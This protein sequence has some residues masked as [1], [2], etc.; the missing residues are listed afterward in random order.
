VKRAVDWFYR[1]LQWL[2]TTLMALLIIPVVMQ[3]LSRH[4]DFVPRYI[5]TEEIARF[6]FIWIIMLGS[7]IAVR[8]GSHFDLDVLP[9]P[10]TERGRAIASLIKHG[11]MFLVAA[12]FL[13]FGYEFSLF[14]LSQESDLL[15]LNMLWIYGAWPLAG[16][17]YVI[18]LIEKIHADVRRFQGRPV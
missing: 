7:M 5:W 13:W 9:T 12:T 14:G 18:F 8:D 2:L 1:A 3:I 10:A 6:L 15:N 17:A 11:A 16:L 4:V